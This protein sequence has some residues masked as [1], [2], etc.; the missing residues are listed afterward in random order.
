MP[1]LSP[2]LSLSFIGDFLLIYSLLTH[3]PTKNKKPE[4]PAV[5]IAI[6]VSPGSLRQNVRLGFPLVSVQ[7]GGSHGVCLSGQ[8]V[9]SRGDQVWLQNLRA[10]PVLP[11]TRERSHVGLYCI[12]FIG[13]DGSS[14]QDMCVA[15]ETLA[16]RNS[17]S[18]GHSNTVGFLH[19]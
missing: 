14:G 1:S 11:M 9:D 5:K 6:T 17:I 19:D 7:T 8:D 15:D 12:T 2:A 13:P 4:T 18:E 10:Q 16:V 3:P